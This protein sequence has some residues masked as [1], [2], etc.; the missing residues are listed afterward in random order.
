MLFSGEKGIM[1]SLKNILI[2]IGVVFLISVVLVLILGI[3]I[4]GTVLFWIMAAVAC[5]WLVIWI[6]YMVGKTRGRRQE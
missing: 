1:K 3:K 5:I 2:G 6:A 4:V